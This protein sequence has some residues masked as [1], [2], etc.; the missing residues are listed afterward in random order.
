MANGQTV[1]IGRVCAVYPDRHTVRVEFDDT[2]IVS[3]EL[4]VKV[5]SAE[6]FQVY[7]LPIVGAQVECTMQSNGQEEGYVS[8]G[9][10]STANIPPFADTDIIGFKCGD[11]LMTYDKKSGQVTVKASTITVIGNVIVQ[12]DVIAN[13]IS[14]VQHVH[15]GVQPGGGNTGSPA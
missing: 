15:G 10:Y 7:C 13:G 3:N 8:G 12:G 11:D 4:A 2:G 1:R 6:E 5:P 9:F 14:L